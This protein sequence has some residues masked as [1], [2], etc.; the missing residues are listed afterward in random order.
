MLRNSLTIICIYV[1]TNVV[2]FYFLFFSKNIIKIKNLMLVM[3]SFFILFYFSFI[4]RIH[5][6]W[7]VRG[8][9]AV[10]FSQQSFT[11]NLKQKLYII[12]TFSFY[13]TLHFIIVSIYCSIL[14]WKNCAIVYVGIHRAYH[15]QIDDFFLL[16]FLLLITFVFFTFRRNKKDK[17]N[18]ENIK[19]L[20]YT[21]D[22]MYKN[23][24]SDRWS[25]NFFLFPFSRKR[26]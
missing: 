14:I 23:R 17:E 12:F 6:F 2:I 15:Y 13:F 8:M 25:V 20:H 19:L 1:S 24:T 16:L 26:N 22:I 4:T 3:I 21:T 9:L 10:E 5:W 11:L 7:T 18:E